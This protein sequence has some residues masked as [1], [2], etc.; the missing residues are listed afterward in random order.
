MEQ[1]EGVP[2]TDYCD[3]HRLTVRDRLG[4]FAAVCAAVQHAHQKGVIHR[5]LKPGNVLVAEVDGRPVPKV[6]D[7]GL[8]KALAAGVLPDVSS[9]LGGTVLGTPLYMA[10]EQADPGTVDID[11]RADVYALGVVL[12]ELLVGNTPLE[13]ASLRQMPFPEVLRQIREVEPP[14]PV[15]RLD[16]SADLPAIA[17]ARGVDPTRLKR[18][19]RGDLEWVARKC[20]EKDRSRRY[21]SAAAVAADV[22]RYLADEPVSAG[23]PSR[24]Y[25]ARKFVRRNRG[26][27]VTAA[28]VF[29]VLVGGVVGTS[30]GMVRAETARANEAE[31]RQLAVL[32]AANEAEQKRI[33]VRAAELE[34]VERRRAEYVAGLMESAFHGID[35]TAEDELGQSF[36]EQLVT[37]LDRLAA[38]VETS[39]GEPVARARMQLAIGQTLR[40]LSEYARAEKLFQQSAA[41][42]REHL[43]P[44]G[45]ATVEAEL[46]I[47]SVCGLLGR[48]DEALALVEDIRRRLPPGS[49]PV[50]R[51]RTSTTSPA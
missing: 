21:E 41:L 16:S 30:V 31:Q 34:A 9:E 1:V 26:P 49:V 14:A 42:R 38:E 22:Q 4:L 18:L 20:L 6:I 48:H 45:F 7:F 11:T 36:K 15:V 28:L 10:P 2:L 43:G 37:R 8:A 27:V 40:G 35:P 47:A 44:N 32:H 17:A 19:V 12:Y 23:P 46:Q 24:W 39:D 3:A 29:L 25:R 5:D 51:T 50:A 13:R 33:A